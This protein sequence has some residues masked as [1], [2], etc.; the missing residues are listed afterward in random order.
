MQVTAPC[1]FGS[2]AV[3]LSILS[4]GSVILLFHRQFVRSP[5]A[6]RLLVHF[7]SALETT[8][9][10]KDWCT[11]FATISVAA[12]GASGVL[13]NQSCTSACSARPFAVLSIVGFVLA[14]LC[15]AI[16]LLA[17]PSVVSRLKRGGVSRS[18]DVYEARAFLF[19]GGLGE[20]IF[21]VGFLAG[22]Q[23]LCFLIGVSAFGLYVIFRG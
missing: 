8:K 14:I 12:I 17:L 3:V 7:D 9:L 15:T 10:L 16:L 18:N 22:L 6:N 23:S 4:A 1:V 2:V 5:E 21:R 11:W 20:R 13:A 19:S